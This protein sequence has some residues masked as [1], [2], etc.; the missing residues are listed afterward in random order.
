MQTDCSAAQLVFEAYYGN[1]CYLPLYIFDGRHLLVA[2]LRKA[3]I[4]AAAGSAEEIARIVTHVRKAWPDMEI[5][6]R[7]TADL[8]VT[9]E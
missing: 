8:P 2:K 4:D 7:P 9:D 1:Y 3:H 5:W 6:L